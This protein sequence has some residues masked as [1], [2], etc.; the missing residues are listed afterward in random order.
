LKIPRGPKILLKKGQNLRWGRA[1]LNKNFKR[2][3]EYLPFP[4]PYPLN[5]LMT[6]S[7]I[8]NFKNLGGGR[9]R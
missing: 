6:V 4:L 8:Y 9:R 5:S 7:I 2:G 3:R 1:V